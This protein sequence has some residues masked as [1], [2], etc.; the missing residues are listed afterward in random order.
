MNKLQVLVVEDRE[1]IA[2]KIQRALVGA[3]YHVIGLAPTL[4]SAATQLEYAERLDAAVLDID[5]RG[6]PV[7][8]VAEQLE[9]RRIPFIFLTGYGASAVGA[10]WRE[11]HRV[12]K[13]FETAS[14]LRALDDAIRRVPPPSG[15][16]AFVGSSVRTRLAMDMIRDTRDAITEARAAREL[17]GAEGE[18]PAR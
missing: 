5:L 14:L 17:P 4:A 3:G 6:E 15:P 2:A 9:A 8:P 10:R 7:F 16:G 12:E 1:I 11:V 18:A 13:P